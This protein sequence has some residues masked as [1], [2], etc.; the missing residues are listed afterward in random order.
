M[1]KTFGYPDNLIFRFFRERP[2]QVLKNNLFPVSN[3]IKNKVKNDKLIINCINNGL[4]K[5]DYE[6]QWTKEIFYV[7]FNENNEIIYNNSVVHLKSINCRICG[8]Y[9]GCILPC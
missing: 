3:E 4:F 1:I 7:E 2:S 9:W 8:N 5:C 6:E